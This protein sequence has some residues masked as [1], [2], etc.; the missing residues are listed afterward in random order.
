MFFFPP[1]TRYRSQTSLL[2]LEL[3]VQPRPGYNPPY[4]TRFQ[5][6]VA[7]T[8]PVLDRPAHTWSIL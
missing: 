8:P 4:F 7:G 1:L 2:L 6:L 3:D 5:S